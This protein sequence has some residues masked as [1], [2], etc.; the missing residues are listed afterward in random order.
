[1]KLFTIGTSGKGLRRF[2]ELIRGAGVD[3]VVDIRLN[4]NSQLA[5]YSKQDDLAFVLELLGIGY[6]HHPE[7]APDE[8]TLSAYRK[9]KDWRAFQERFGRLIEERNMVVAGRDITSRYSRPCLLCAEDDAAK[10][11]RRFVAEHW[12]EWIPNVE[13]EHLK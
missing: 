11:H 9:D 13:I 4:N 7:L 6:E 1:M 3:C 5:G 10:C 2:I 12:A 8:A